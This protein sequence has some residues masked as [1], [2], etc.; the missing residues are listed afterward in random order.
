[1]PKNSFIVLAAMVFIWVD[2]NFANFENLSTTT[3][4]ASVTLHSERHVIKSIE[5]LSNG[6][7]GIGRGLCSLKFFLVYQLGTLALYT[8][9]NVVLYIF[10]HFGSIESLFQQ[11]SCCFITMV[12]CHG[13]IMHF[14]YNLRVQLFVWHIDS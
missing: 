11:L 9:V 14:L 7:N 12:F 13:R 8:C 6:P 3:K 1:M 2:V 5:T 10:L 4:M